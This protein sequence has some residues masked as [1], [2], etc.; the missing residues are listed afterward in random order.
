MTKIYREG[1]DSLGQFLKA[2]HM[3]GTASGYD[4]RLEM[5]ASLGNDEGVPS[6]GGFAV[7]V[8]YSDD[9]HER[10]YS[11]GSILDLGGNTVDGNLGY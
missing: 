1:F 2:V 10:I 6:L 11:T 3:H 5:V 4:N 8:E 9:L 7:P